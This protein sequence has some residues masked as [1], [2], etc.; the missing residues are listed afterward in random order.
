MLPIQKGSTEV[1]RVS[2]LKKIKSG[3]FKARKAIPA[4]VRAA[5]QK[6]YGQGWE[7]IFSMPAG[8]PPTVAK[9]KHAEWLALVER[10]IAA[11]AEPAATN[12]PAL[13]IQ[14]ADALAGDWYRQYVAAREAEPGDAIGWDD[15]LSD[16][17]DALDGRVALPDDVMADAERFIADRGLHLSP[18]SMEKWQIALA[19]EYRAAAATLLGR[20]EGNRG[21]DAHLDRLAPALEPVGSQPVALG[22]VGGTAKA[23]KSPPQAA[24]ALLEAYAAD[25]GFA[26]STLRRWKPVMATLDTQPWQ[27]PDWDAQEWI[28]SLVTEG[29]S[30]TTVHRT[31]LV[32][33]KTLM[34]WALRRKRI[35]TN[36]FTDVVMSVPKKVITRETGRAFSDAE[37]KTI[38]SAALQVPLLPMGS[39]GSEQSASRRW[40]PWLMAYTGARAGEVAQLRAGDIDPA[41]KTILITPEAGTVKTSKARVVPVHADLIEQGF[42]GFV[43]AV[44]AA[45]GRGGALF[46]DDSVPTKADAKHRRSDVAANKLGRWVRSLG[47][48]DPGISPNHAWR[49][50][51]ETRARRAGIEASIRDAI[52]GHAPRSTGEGYDHVTAEDMAEALERFPRYM[53]A[54]PPHN[55]NA[56]AV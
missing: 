55:G 49:H 9:A 41:R 20:S 25:R 33:C 22:T 43:K 21:R 31:W 4:A 18:V 3:A 44:L 47:I 30:K 46:W 39:A 6:L 56:K 40:L 51:F 19:R 14:Q 13:T 28:D 2:N 48:T 24:T 26:P 52:S 10:R 17:E 36:P 15:A 29:R 16:A 32:A 5:Y 27:R 11:L 45:K 8:T 1:F 42:L 12:A 34:R 54:A 37:A 23:R 7:V 50:L 35:A 38:L 53:L